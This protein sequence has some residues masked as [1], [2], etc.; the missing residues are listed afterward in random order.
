MLC[1][2]CPFA[3]KDKIKVER[4]RFTH[5]GVADTADMKVFSDAFYEITSGK[6]KGNLVHI[7][8]IF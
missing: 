4:K 2:N 6:Y 7:F 1:K 8:D 3:A 5:N